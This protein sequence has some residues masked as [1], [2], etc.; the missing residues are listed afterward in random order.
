MNAYKI[1]GVS[2]IGVFVIEGGLEIVVENSVVFDGFV[3]N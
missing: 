1:N 2:R 3:M